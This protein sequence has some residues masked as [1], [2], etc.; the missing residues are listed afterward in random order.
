MPV[1]VTSTV[2]PHADAQ[3]LGS[4]CTR[5]VVDV[6]PLHREMPVGVTFTVA[7]HVAGVTFPLLP[8][9]HCVDR[10]RLGRRGGWPRC[11]RGL[12]TLGIT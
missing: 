6:M 4:L 8:K 2:A 1:G 9:R 5:F 3:T 7:R 11:V 12:L 10:V